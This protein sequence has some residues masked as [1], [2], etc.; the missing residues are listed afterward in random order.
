MSLF[1]YV[2]RFPE[3]SHLSGLEQRKLLQAA[4]DRL[5]ASWP[6]LP[7]SFAWSVLTVL[8][9]YSV[10]FLA[11]WLTGWST[12]AGGAAAVMVILGLLFVFEQVY[13]RHLQRTTLEMLA[14]QSA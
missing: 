1:N 9:C 12:L 14:E 3:I 6:T 10:G 8:G 7:A 5:D 11:A 4:R 2:N 13:A